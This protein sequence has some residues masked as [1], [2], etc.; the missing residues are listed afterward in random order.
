[1]AAIYEIPLT[2]EAQE[3]AIAIAGT[4]YQLT[5][6][7]NEYSSCWVLDIADKD[8]VAILNGIPLLAGEDLLAQ[9]GY[10]NFGGTLT[11]V[12]DGDA[13]ANPSYDGLGSI[14]HVYFTVA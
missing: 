10:M 4:T 12:V 5:L 7:W 8:G 6:Y 13:T 3:F 14:G 1:M 9:Y 2:P 11:A